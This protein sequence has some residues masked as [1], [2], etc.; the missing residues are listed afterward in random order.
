MSSGISKD[1]N[2][3]N[4]GQYSEKITEPIDLSKAYV[5]FSI[6]FEER[7]NEKKSIDIKDIPFSK[8][9]LEFRVILIKEFLE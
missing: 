1:K 2:P 7:I 8:L 6:F 4:Y 9:D 3:L 5:P